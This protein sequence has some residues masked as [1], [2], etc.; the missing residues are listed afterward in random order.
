MPSRNEPNMDVWLFV[1][2]QYQ[3]IYSR[4]EMNKKYHNDMKW[5]AFLAEVTFITDRKT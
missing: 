5:N 2:I 3:P 4:G 1:T